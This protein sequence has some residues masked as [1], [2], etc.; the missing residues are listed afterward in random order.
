[1]VFVH[2]ARQ[3]ERW[4]YRLMDCQVEN[5]HLLSLGAE[6]I[7]RSDFL[8][9]IRESVHCQPGHEWRM[10]WHWGAEADP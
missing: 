2:V 3:L 10:D 6:R 5:T 9:I 1:V 7:P 8:S 4:G